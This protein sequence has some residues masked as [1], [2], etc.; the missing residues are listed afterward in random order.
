MY[1]FKSEAADKK[2]PFS[3]AIEF[4]DI[5]GPSMLRAAAKNH[6]NVIPLCHHLQYDDFI[7]LFK[8]NKGIFTEKDRLLFAEDVFRL[9]S[10]YD[11]QIYNYFSNKDQEQRKINC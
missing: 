11:N 10:E 8:K 1:P 2:L 4:I 9:T 5:G 6:A 3:K 7:S